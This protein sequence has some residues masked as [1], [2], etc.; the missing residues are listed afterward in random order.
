MTS[1]RLGPP[2]PIPPRPVMS[3]PSAFTYRSQSP[4]VS[5]TQYPQ[6][7]QSHPTY[8]PR[9]DDSYLVSRASSLSPSLPPFFLSVSKTLLSVAH[10][11][12]LTSKHDFFPWD[13]GVQALIRANELIGHILDPSAFVDPSCPDLCPTPPPVLTMSSSPR[14]I[15]SSNRWWAEDNVAQHILVTRLGGVPQRLL[16]SSL[17]NTRTALSIYQILTH[18]YGTCNFA[19]C[20]E[21][22]NSLHNSTCTT[23]RVSD[24]VSK[25]R[26]GLVKLQS[27]R[28]A[29]NV[30]I[31]ISLFVCGLPA[32]PAF[33]TH[34]ADLPCNIAAI[35]DDHD[36]GAFI[37]LTDTVLELDTIF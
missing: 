31:C 26:V 27:A 8:R 17:T 20:T 30:K 16:P 29:Y 32:I 2:P 10:I 28:F 21:L 12:L 1:R 33:N 24:Y 13:K 3:E 25:W 7:V 18:Y 19:D 9:Q 14:D 22:L 36:Y 4:Y 11:P 34:C 15:D 6:P 23:G 5:V 37:G 35:S